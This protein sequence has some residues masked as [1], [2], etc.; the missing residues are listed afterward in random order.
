MCIGIALA[1]FFL[2]RLEGET[3]FE[4]GNGA[5]LL[6]YQDRCLNAITLTPISFAGIKLEI[7][8]DMF[9][10]FWGLFAFFT[11]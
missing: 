4:G 8:G 5:P 11:H 7:T 9:C 2:S 10:C 6:G 1:F 3:R